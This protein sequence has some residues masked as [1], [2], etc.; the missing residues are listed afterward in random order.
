MSDVRSKIAKRLRQLRQA[1]DWTI[2]ETASRLSA[3]SSATISASRYGNW[4]QGIRAPKL[5]QFAELGEL[6]SKPAAYIAG[7]SDHDGVASESSSHVVPKS[8]SLG[9]QADLT[10]ADESLALSRELLAELHLSANRILL[11]RVGD[12]SMKGTADE[13]DRV[14]ID[15]SVT[16]VTRDDLFALLVNGRILLRWIRQDLLGKFIVQAADNDRYPNQNLT[17]EELGNLTIIGRVAL[18]GRIY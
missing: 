18:I 17:S 8:S 5:E 2:E 6:F 10:Q 16:S 11:I 3:I 7:L 4:E 9:R 13:G 14:L 12:S 15:L 1:K